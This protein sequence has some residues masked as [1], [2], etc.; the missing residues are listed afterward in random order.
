[1]I[2]G[3]VYE[4]LSSGYYKYKEVA[5]NICKDEDKASDVV[6][7]VMESCLKMPK[8]TLQDIYNKDGLLWYIIRMITLNIKSN[9]SRYYYIYNKYYEQLDNNK[10]TKSYMPEFYENKPEDTTE[11]ITHIRLD[12][13]EDLL[14]NLYWY[15]RELFLTYYRDGYTLDTLADKTGISR[16]SIFNTLKKVKNYIKDNINE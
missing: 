6:Q 14:S 2:K 5:L 10:S 8:A 4:A 1:M 13:I 15:D 3:D 7:M 12:K 11:S 9:T 16:T